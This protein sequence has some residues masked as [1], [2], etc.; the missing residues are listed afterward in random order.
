MERPETFNVVA[1]S[2][3]IVAP[4][5]DR[6]CVVRVLLTVAP[7]SVASPQTFSVTAVSIPETFAV[8][9]DSVVIVAPGA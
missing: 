5:A 1:D 6:V 7:D 8:V 9:V 4:A 2:V 3:V